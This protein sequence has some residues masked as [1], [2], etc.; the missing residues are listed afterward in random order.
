MRW[1]LMSAGISIACAFALAVLWTPRNA[2][3]DEDLPINSYTYFEVGLNS[4]QDVNDAGIVL[5]D[6]DGDVYL[7]WDAGWK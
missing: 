6:L 4:V 1:K 3:A 2:H 5:G 7:V